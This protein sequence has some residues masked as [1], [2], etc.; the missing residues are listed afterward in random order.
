MPDF[1]RFPAFKEAVVWEA[2]V[3]AGDLIYI[4]HKWLHQVRN[5]DYTIAMSYNYVDK[6]NLE[7]HLSWH[8]SR[9]A[10]GRQKHATSG[11]E[12]D[13]KESKSC[14]SAYG[15]DEYFPVEY[16]PDPQR[17]DEP[18]GH[19]FKRHS[20]DRFEGFNRTAYDEAVEVSRLKYLADDMDDK[21]TGD[22][23]SA[24]T[25]RY[26][27]VCDDA[28]IDAENPETNVEI[29]EAQLKNSRALTAELERQLRHHKDLRD[30]ATTETGEANNSDS[31]SGDNL[32]K[33]EETSAETITDED[34]DEL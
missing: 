24:R 10:L 30:D 7:D 3:T 31:V 17:S 28:Q 11:H 21:S 13:A 1:D 29:L 9:I 19:F 23:A 27:N 15:A 18:W 22:L 25:K 20:V 5:M 26:N 32:A 14:V 16:E 8:Y 2:N 12:T 33:L 4:P 34:K 6:Y